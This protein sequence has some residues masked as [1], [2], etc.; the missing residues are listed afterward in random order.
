M[1]LQ[2]WQWALFITAAFC[3]G[4]SKSGF[5][6][7]SILSVFLLTE[8]FGAKSQVGVGLP[9]LVIADLIVFPAFRKHGNWKEVW[10]LLPP[11]LIGGA[12]GIFVLDSFNDN[13]MRPIVGGIILLMVGLQFLRK[14]KPQTVQELAMSKKFSVFAGFTGGVATVIA[15]AA[16]PIQQLYLLSKQFEKME[17]IGIGARFF[18]LIN[19]I[20]LPILGGLS[21]VSKDSLLLNLYVIP[22]I[23]IGVFTGKSVLK[24]VSYKWFEF[25]LVSFALVAG[26]KLMFF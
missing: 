18:L 2:T 8:V 13:T 17:L 15:N 4:L 12:L 14:W 26:V 22:M 9:L 19:L 25:L 5:A 7:F 23:F 3:I 16:G 11:A 24:H 10:V 20:K 21:M 1:E 6:G